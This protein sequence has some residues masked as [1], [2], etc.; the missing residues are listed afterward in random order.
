MFTNLVILVVYCWKYMISRLFF[1]MSVLFL[2]Y[3]AFIY[4][5]SLENVD[6]EIENNC[7]PVSTVL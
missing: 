1:S 7:R 4:L 5:E 3:T 6:I 2:A